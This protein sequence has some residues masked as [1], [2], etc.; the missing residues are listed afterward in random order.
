M[1]QLS[2][3]CATASQGPKRGKLP[4]LN[5]FGMTESV[6]LPTKVTTSGVSYGLGWRAYN[7]PLACAILAASTRLL[8]PSLLMASDK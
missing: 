8:A 7:H 6:T 2:E 5:T 3:S 1:P 4:T